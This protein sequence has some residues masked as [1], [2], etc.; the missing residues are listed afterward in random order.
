[1]NILDE[2][3]LLVFNEPCTLREFLL[4]GEAELKDALRCLLNH[5]L[6]LVVEAGIA[7]KGC[8]CQLVPAWQLP[9]ELDRDGVLRFGGRRWEVLD[10]AEAVRVEGSDRKLRPS[11]LQVE[12]KLTSR[13]WVELSS[14]VERGECGSFRIE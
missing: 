10:V 6:L 2:L 9:L 3:G 4:S 8:L 7:H 11:R 13:A 5:P 12:A 14:L 1:M